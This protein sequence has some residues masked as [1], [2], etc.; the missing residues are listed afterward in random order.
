MKPLCKT[1][2]SSVIVSGALLCAPG[3]LAQDGQDTPG[4]ADVKF[5]QAETDSI[6]RAYATVMASTSVL[7]LR[8]ISP[9]TLWQQ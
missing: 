2:I 3:A 6:N 1:L 9:P 8:R 5:T 4:K 7:T